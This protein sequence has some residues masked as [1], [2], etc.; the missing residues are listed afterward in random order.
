MLNVGVG[1]VGFHTLSSAACWAIFFLNTI[2][3]TP[4]ALT[5][6]Q[7]LSQGLSTH[8]SLSPDLQGR[9]IISILQME[10]LRCRELRD[11]L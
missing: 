4:W 2:T 11:F 10:K 3:P 8:R 7:E 5:T 1:A 9:Y 6:R